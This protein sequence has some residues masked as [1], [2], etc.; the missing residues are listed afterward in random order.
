MKQ[1]NLTY[2]E[3][4]GWGSVEAYNAAKTTLTITLQEGWN[5]ISV[6]KDDGNGGWAELDYFVINGTDKVYNSDDFEG[7]NTTS[8]N[9]YRL[10]GEQAGMISRTYNEDNMTWNRYSG[11]IDRFWS[12]KASNCTMVGGIDAVGQGLEWHLNVNE[13]GKY[14]ITV[15][16]AH[17]YGDNFVN[18]SL[19]HSATHLRGV[20]MNNAEL[21]EYKVSDLAI[22]AG[23]GWGTPVVN[24][25]TFEIDLAKGTNFIYLI[26][27]LQNVY[28]QIDYIELTYIG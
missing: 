20:T 28:C 6:F 17:S 18:L 5:R 11:N 2:S 9:T 26:K 21:Q 27:E 13:G 15:V 22:G 4:T 19:Y 3:N 12:E 10:E 14:R 23:S 24:T 7:V 1:G 8:P 16:Y 25:Q